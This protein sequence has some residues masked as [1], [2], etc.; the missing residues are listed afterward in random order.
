M[1]NQTEQYYQT[2]VSKLENLGRKLKIIS[3]LNGVFNWIA[4]LTIILAVEIVI[5][6][7]LSLPRWTLMGMLII[8]CALA[9]W[10]GYR[11]L[12]R[13]FLKD[14]SKEKIAVYIEESYPGFEN[15]LQSAL[16][17]KGKINNN[18]YGYS[19]SFIKK[20]IEQAYEVI[21]DVD[22]TLVFYQEKRHL[23]RS[24]V[25]MLIAI[26][27]FVGMS[28]LMPDSLNNLANA[29][30]K[31]PQAPVEIVLPKISNVQPGNLT[32]KSGENVSISAEVSGAIGKKVLLSF[33][34]ADSP[35]QSLEMVP[36][37]GA[38][39]PRKQTT[40]KNITHSFEYYIS[41]NDTQSSRYNITV[42]S[43][44]I[45]SDFGLTLNFPA[46]TGLSS[47][48]LEPNMGDITA[49]V[50]T[51]VQFEGKSNKPLA[52]ASLVFDESGRVKLDIAEDKTTISGRFTIE[53]S[54]YYHA[55]LTDTTEMSNS[56]PIKYKINV[57]SDEPPFVEILAPGKDTVLDE[58]MQV[59]LKINST[60]DYGVDKIKLVYQVEGR[61]DKKSVVIKDLQKPQETLLTEYAW[62]LAKLDL[63]TEDV[64]SYHIEALDADNISGPNIG[65]SKTYTVRYPSVNELYQEIES[66]QIAQK[67]GMESI[68][69]KQDEATESVEELIDKIRK[70]QELTWRD[71][72]ELERVLKNQK[73]IGER[74]KK[75][76]EQVQNTA[77]DVQKKQLFDTETLQ[78]YQELQ[79]LMDEA[80]TDEQKEILRELNEAMQK[81]SLTEKE[82]KLMS[83]NFDQKK[84]K[85]R[86]EQ[87]LELYKNMLVQQKIEAAA[88]K[89]KELSERQ[90]KFIEKTQNLMENARP[91]NSEQE[92]KNL[93][94]N[95]KSIADDLEHLENDLEKISDELVKEEKYE[96]IGHE[97]NRL[98]K[99]SKEQ[100]NVQALKNASEKM[101]Q[102]NLTE[103]MQKAMQAQSGLQ[104]LSSQLHNVVE[105][106]RGQD[107]SEA[108]A[109]IRK[110]I[111]EGLYI[112]Q[113]HEKVMQ[114]TRE[115]LGSQN[116]SQSKSGQKKLHKLAF[117]ELNLADGL[118]ML[119]NRLW[120]LSKGQGQINP[121]IIWALNSSE[122]AIKRSARAL[123]D[124][125]PSLAMPIQR[126]A[127]AYVNDA[128][129]KLLESLENMNQQMSMS[130]LQNMFEQ[131]QQ[132][133]QNQ[134]QLN[135]MTQ[136]VG[137]QMRKRGQAPGM[138]EMMKRMAFEQSLIREA[139]ERI[140]EKMEKLSEALGDL[141]EVAKEMQEVEEKLGKGKIDRELIEKQQRILTRMLES[142]K[143]LQKR[144]LSKKRKGET[145][146]QIFSDLK[147]GSEE[148]NPELIK[149][150]K[151]IQNEL[152]SGGIENWPPGYR[153]L[154]KKYYKALSKKTR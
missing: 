8:W 44:P 13:G 53:K 33:R 141:Y 51:S 79:K 1:G 82:K 145:A 7:I 86:L 122:D 26:I 85:Q 119:A 11:Y 84:F 38:T 78:K 126:H 63:F 150:V 153:E 34:Y 98:S 22:E 3:I 66:E 81:Q 72:K 6:R 101:N 102:G 41:V 60:D 43:E 100:K 147:T 37:S 61:E 135:E 5:D 130:G 42:A 109:S 152:R 137:E 69:D 121:K 88:N 129:A 139:T 59:N 46:Y 73:E 50:G 18:I 148:I 114:E 80:L 105:F 40:L 57:I 15:R 96:K 136:R 28:L 154:L 117:D 91:K 87:M 56:S 62:D 120:E 132:L 58:S 52:S 2:I 128:V 32:V 95:E 113:T 144:Q 31:I 106:M 146:E 75:L 30:V 9:I 108:V 143:S 12:L 27:L 142:E 149:Q 133:I 70:S 115:N 138:E 107:A 104:M 125:K 94:E 64:V 89:A 77:K 116:R 4:W 134:G 74:A 90:E 65:V 83:A 36:I 118:S 93:S 124:Q 99:Q 10:F 127:L 92:T 48:A 14:T 112:S 71:E 140:A 24:C 29:F 76:S 35:W 97:L 123:E 19:I 151:E 49:L 39:S 23:S 47:Q 111:N 16:Q 54:Q 68:L 110:A 55:F 103:S 21:N 20:L 67:E 25:T 45:L 17:L 131:L